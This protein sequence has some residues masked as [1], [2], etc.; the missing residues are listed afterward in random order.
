MSNLPVDA[1]AEKGY[2]ATWFNPDKPMGIAIPGTAIPGH[3]PIY[4]NALYPGIF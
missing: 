2:D 3:S 1:V 4:K